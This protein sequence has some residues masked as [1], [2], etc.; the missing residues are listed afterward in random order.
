MSTYG[1]PWEK[2]LRVSNSQNTKAVGGRFADRNERPV[3]R[4]E[5][6]PESDGD[7]PAPACSK[8]GRQAAPAA[9]S[10][11]P[12]GSSAHARRAKAAVLLRVPAQPPATLR[13]RYGRRARL[14]NTPERGPGRGPHEPEQKLSPSLCA[15]FT[16]RPRHLS[17]TRT[18][19]MM[20]NLN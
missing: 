11:E 1:K 5:W 15:D 17:R 14:A 16:L 7:L 9:A 12:V 18:P 4:L 10:S 13:P 3:G 2:F 6:R 8:T 20:R 19:Q